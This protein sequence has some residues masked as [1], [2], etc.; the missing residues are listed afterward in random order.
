MIEACPGLKIALG[1][2]AVSLA[3]AKAND[4]AKK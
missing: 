4:D 2:A 3:T 1:S